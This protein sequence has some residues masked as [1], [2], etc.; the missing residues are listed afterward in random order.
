MPSNATYTEN[1][2]RTAQSIGIKN[3]LLFEIY[4][5]V[6]SSQ[7]GRWDKPQWC[8]SPG[9]TDFWQRQGPEVVL[10]SVGSAPGVPRA[11]LGKVG[12]TLHINNV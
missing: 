6:L 3:N 11:F 8:M 9:K 2:G 7:Q 10:V 4:V 12:F 1:E 5:C